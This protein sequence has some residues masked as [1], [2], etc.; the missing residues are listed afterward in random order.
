[1]HNFLKPLGNNLLSHRSCPP[2]QPCFCTPNTS[3]LLPLRYTDC[4]QPPPPP[5]YPPAR[6]QH[7]RPN[8]SV[9]PF[10]YPSKDSFKFLTFFRA[11]ECK[12][13]DVPISV[14]KKKKNITLCPKASN[15]RR[16]CRRIGS[17]RQNSTIINSFTLVKTGKFWLLS[18]SV[19]LNGKKIVFLL[20]FLTHIESS[21]KSR[22]LV[23]DEA[24]RRRE[25][26]GMKAELASRLFEGQKMSPPHKQGN[27]MD[28]IKDNKR[29]RKKNNDNSFTCILLPA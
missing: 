26:R 2:T 3:T 16:K 20:F 15:T 17:S 10:P 11:A 25:R 4:V 14:T 28:K 29:R 19:A 13:Y 1:M 12:S 24:P 8:S 18:I 9:H 5:P 7:T 22:P 6:P 21:G 27:Y 23:F